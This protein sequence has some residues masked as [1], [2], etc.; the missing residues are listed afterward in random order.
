M[1]RYGACGSNYKKS[2]DKGD[3]VQRRELEGRPLAV[4]MRGVIQWRTEDRL[5]VHVHVHVQM[6]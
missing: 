2:H 3:R 5:D 6:Q 4:G 1:P